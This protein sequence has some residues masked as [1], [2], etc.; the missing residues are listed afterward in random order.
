MAKAVTHKYVIILMMRYEYHH[1]EDRVGTVDNDKENVRTQYSM[2]YV[3]GS[4][5]Q[6]R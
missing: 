2:V 1:M 6:R 3:K 4:V 5:L